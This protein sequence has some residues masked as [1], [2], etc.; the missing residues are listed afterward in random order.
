MTKRLFILSLIL[1]SPISMADTALPSPQEL[2]NNFDRVGVAKKESW[3]KGT[4]PD[5]VPV[6]T[7]RSVG[8]IY[9]IN[10]DF[11]SS[12][13]ITKGEHHK[14]EFSHS[15]NVCVNLAYGVIGSKNKSIEEQV[16][17]IVAGAARAKDREF[18][19]SIDD[20]WFESQL[21]FIGNNPVL[22]C[23]ISVMSTWD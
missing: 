19:D 21:T 1:L 2:I 9:S 10:K 20:F 12:L 11:A 15:K 3:K 22:A 5:G 14:A 8:D 23:K 7:S 16:I 13:S 6:L 18:A 17:N 4:S